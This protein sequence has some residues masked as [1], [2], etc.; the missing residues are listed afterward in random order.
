MDLNNFLI[1]KKETKLRIKIL[2]FLFMGI[3]QSLFSQI[4]EERLILDRKREPEIKKIEKK[5]TSVETIKNY[6]PQSKKIEDSLNLKYDITNVPAV[7]DFKT[8]TIQGEDISPKLG[9]DAQNNYLQF[10]MG[11]Y[12]KV[13]L[14]GNISYLLQNKTEVGADAH[15]LRTS[16]LKDDYA[17]DSRSSKVDL[18]AFLNYYAE[19][20]KFNVTTSFGSHDYNYYGIYALQPASDINLKQ[21][22]QNISINGYYDD[23]SNNILNDVRVRTSFLK[24][25]FDAKESS[26][27]LDLNL[28]KHGLDL[29]IEEVALNVDLGLGIESTNTTFDLLKQ[30]SA[31]YL[32]GSIEPKFTFRRG[33]HHLMIGSGFSFLNAKISNNTFVEELKNTKSYW[34]PRAEILFATSD[35]ANLYIGVDGGLQ[36]NSYAAMLQENPFLVSD[37]EIRPTET[38]YRIYFG[39]KGDVNQNIKYDIAAG[40]SKMRNVLFFQGNTIFD[41]F[42]TL[43]RSAYNFASTFSAVYDDG[44]MNEVRASLQYFPLENLIIDGNL[45]YNFYKLDHYDKIYNKPNVNASLGAKYTMLDKKLMLGFKGFFVSQKF[46]N[47]FEI[48]PDALDPTL[49]SSVENKEGKVSGFADFNISAE[50]KIHKNFS[51]FVLGNNLTNKKYETYNG[52]RVLG[53]QFTGGLKVSF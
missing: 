30:Q 52:Y 23:Y 4:K 9:K 41:Q 12:G 31:N 13:L 25:K 48:Q 49:F 38:K 17:W 26:G 45:N 2:S 16:G 24:D 1:F 3:F 29:P 46:T 39:I 27:A 35:I 33:K 51:A 40:F 10:G 5:K 42:N 50:Y 14:D 36:H 20:G 21:Q 53:A 7:S 43:N 47:F 22:V 34:F 32:E 44:S 6:P 37:Q 11:N 15:V 8:S 19:K 28:S 18:G